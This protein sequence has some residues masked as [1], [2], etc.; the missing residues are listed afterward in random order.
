MFY[1]HTR[2]V[3]QNHKRDKKKTNRLTLLVDIFALKEN[4]NLSKCFM[5][6]M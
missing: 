5:F 6:F 3:T 2:L 1:T 4:E